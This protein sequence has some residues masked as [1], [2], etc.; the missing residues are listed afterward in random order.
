MTDRGADHETGSIRI[1]SGQMPLILFFAGHLITAII[2]GS[3]GLSELR[4]VREA[5]DE[6]TESQKSQSAALQEH[7]EKGAHNVAATLLDILAK[8]DERLQNR[9]DAIE[10]DH[11]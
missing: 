7:V 6:L 8:N 5:I 11:R 2:V 10:G 1:R 3:I 4:H 9:M